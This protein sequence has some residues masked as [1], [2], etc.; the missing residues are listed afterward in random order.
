MKQPNSPQDSS[1]RHLHC[2]NEECNAKYPEPLYNIGFNAQIT[3]SAARPLW[4]C[5]RHIP[6]RI[7]YPV[8]LHGEELKKVGRR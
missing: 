5:S 2:A 8:G 1:V 6:E 4:V 3:D 7:T